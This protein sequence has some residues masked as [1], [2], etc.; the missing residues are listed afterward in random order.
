MKERGIQAGIWQYSNLC[1]A[2]Y[3]WAVSIAKLWY[4]LCTLGYLS[5]RA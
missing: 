2:F 1:S 3:Y 5:Q 4:G